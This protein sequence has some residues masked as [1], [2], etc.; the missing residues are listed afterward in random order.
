VTQRRR[1][2]TLWVPGLLAIQ[3]SEPIEVRAGVDRRDEPAAVRIT[4]DLEGGAVWTLAFEP[5]EAAYLASGMAVE[6]GVRFG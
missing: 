4:I 1:S 2:N 3:R 6:A 5:A